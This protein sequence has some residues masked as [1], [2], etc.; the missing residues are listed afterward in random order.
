M[1]GAAIGDLVVAEA[2]RWIGTPYCHQSSV[3]GVGCDC[4]GLL[5]GVWRAIHGREPVDLPAYTTDWGEAAAAE[6]VLEAAARHLHSVDGRR[7]TGDVLVFRWRRGSIA[8]HLGILTTGDRFIHAWER[9]GVVE[10]ALARSWSTR[11]A[12]VFR[13]PDR[14]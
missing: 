13:F 2:R 11:I 10:V 1:T 9:A 4:L 6:Y 3:R 12:A 5:R 7:R 14:T 8:K